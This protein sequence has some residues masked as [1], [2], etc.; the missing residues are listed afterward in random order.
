VVFRYWNPWEVP[1]NADLV[2]AFRNPPAIF[3]PRL[4]EPLGREPI[5][6][7]TPSLLE[8]MA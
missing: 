5:G 8:E 7:L 2:D 4:P 3:R 1:L 6:S